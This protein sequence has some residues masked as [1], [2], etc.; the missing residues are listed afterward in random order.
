MDA[1]GVGFD[2]FACV[3]QGE[4]FQMRATLR[5]RGLQG[6]SDYVQLPQ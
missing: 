3:E 4:R 6:I 5:C 1:G 2:S